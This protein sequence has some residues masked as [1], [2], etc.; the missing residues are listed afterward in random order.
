MNKSSFPVPPEK[1]QKQSTDPKKIRSVRLLR[2]VASRQV[3]TVD[4]QIFDS[5]GRYLSTITAVPDICA[6]ATVTGLDVLKILDGDVENLVHR[7]ADNLV[8]ANG[9]LL[10]T[11]GRLDYIVRFRELCTPVTIIFSPE[12]SG[13]LLSWFVCVELGLLST[14]YPEPV[15]VNS[16]NRAVAV[17][18]AAPSLQTIH[19]DDLSAI[20]EQLL[21]E[22]AIVDVFDCNN[23]LRTMAGSPMFIELQSNAVPSP[24][25]GARSIPFAQRD[26][27]KKMLDDMVG[28]SS[29]RLFSQPTGYTHSSSSVNQ[30]ERFIFVLTLPA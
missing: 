27:V 18:S 19:V 12:H 23:N 24:V 7:G 4:V 16:I 15:L 22:F 1:R 5:R 2:V 28:V 30:A 29:N 3:P 25:N 10:E 13:M 6:K 21:K 20:K 8:A 14:N 9:L 11:A 26:A 17:D